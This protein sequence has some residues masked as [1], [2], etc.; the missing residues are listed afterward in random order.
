MDKGYS[1]PPTH[2][3]SGLDIMAKTLDNNGIGV[4][5]QLFNIDPTTIQ[6][7]EPVGQAQNSYKLGITSNTADKK[8]SQQLSDTQGERGGLESSP[9][10][11]VLQNSVQGEQGEGKTESSSS[12][13][14]SPSS[15]SSES[16]VFKTR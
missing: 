10:N 7:P 12:P 2:L 16:I 5:Q 14:P 1:P 15:I 3:P 8:I 6:H 13:T 9:P 4:S 11:G